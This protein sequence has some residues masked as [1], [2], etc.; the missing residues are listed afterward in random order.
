M[1]LSSS[2]RNRN[3]SP[4]GPDSVG[5]GNPFSRVFSRGR[6]AKYKLLYSGRSLISEDESHQCVY[7]REDEDGFKGVRLDKNIVQ[8]AGKALT[9]QFTRLGPHVLPLSEQVQINYLN[10]FK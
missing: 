6:I 10:T 7:Q 5:G 9:K 8:V 4:E 3:L 2:S 1:L